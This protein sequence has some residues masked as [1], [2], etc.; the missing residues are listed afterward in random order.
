[1]HPIN[2]ATV[3]RMQVCMTSL[4]D[5]HE[6]GCTPRMLS[7]IIHWI[8]DRQADDFGWVGTRFERKPT[9]VKSDRNSASPPLH[10]ERWRIFRRF[11]C[12]RRVRF[13]FHFQRNFERA[14]A[15]WL[16]GICSLSRLRSIWCVAFL[17]GLD[18]CAMAPSPPE[19]LRF[20]LLST[21]LCSTAKQCFAPGSNACLGPTESTQEVVFALADRHEVGCT[22]RMLSQIIHWILDRQADDFGWVGTRFERKPTI[23]KSDRN[24]ASPPLHFERWRIFRRFFCNRRVRFFFHFQRN[25]ERALASWL[26]GICSLSRLRSIWC[27]AFLYGLDLCAMAPSPPEALRFWLLSTKLCSTAKQCFAP[28]SNA[29]LGPTE[30]TQEVVFALADRHEVGCTPRMLSQIIHWILDRQADDFGWVGT[31][32][33]RKPTIVKSDRNSASPPLHFERW[34]IFRRFFCNRRVRFFFHFQRNFERALASWLGGICSLSRLRSIWCVAFLYGLDLCAMAPSP[35]EALRFWLLSTKLCS[36]AKQCP[37]ESTQEVVFALADR[38][39]VGCTP[40]MLSQIIHW[41]LDRQADDFG[42][43]GTRFER[44]PTIVKSD[45]NSASPPLHFERWRIFRRF[46]CNRRVRFFFHFQRNFERALASCPGGICNRSRL[47]SIWCVAFLYGLDL[48]AM[49][50]SPPE[51]WPPEPMWLCMLSLRAIKVVE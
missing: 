25:F 36:T 51:A 44:K 32:F 9:I 13:F 17:Y 1:M 47:R 10:F 42:W 37:T 6:V 14:L 30:S 28:G 43:V 35:P 15:S 11:F 4:H 3:Q 12:N 26:G 31:R 48:C 16:G 41:I 27:V 50:P 24:S 5:P 8:L 45:R 40:R 20:W 29:C 2:D 21:K 19:A 46:F 34:R 18:L 49:A 39:E 38:H 22:P 7:Q 23:V 33:E